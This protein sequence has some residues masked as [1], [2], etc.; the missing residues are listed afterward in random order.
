MSAD[1]FYLTSEVAER[2]RL[3]EHTVRRVARD[4]GIGFLVSRRLGYRFTDADVA[5]LVA[6]L[7]AKPAAS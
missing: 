5:A 4:N 6:A 2:L 1:V 7:R 3:P